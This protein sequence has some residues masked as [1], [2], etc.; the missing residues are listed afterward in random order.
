MPKF[1]KELV[2][3]ILKLR[4]RVPGKGYLMFASTGVALCAVGATALSTSLLDVAQSLAREALGERAP[5][6]GETAPTGLAD[7][8][9]VA[10]FWAVILVGLAIVVLSFVGF[11]R[12]MR[13]V[14]PGNELDGAIA[15]QVQPSTTLT[16]LL[17]VVALRCDRT[18]DCRA[19]SANGVTQELTDGR[20]EAS[21]FE[22]FLSKACGRVADA[23][24]VGWERRDDIY[25]IL[26]GPRQA[27]A[28]S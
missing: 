19:L 6:A 27:A 22:D 1:I 11:Y 9:T 15:I 4:S 16:D 25:V 18:V 26:V 8:I 23:R 12:F 10:F 28:A 7:T 2:D 20:L 3:L 17:K 21:D 24:T 5:P 13:N 14:K